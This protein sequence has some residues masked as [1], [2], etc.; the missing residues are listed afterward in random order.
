MP[1]IIFAIISVFVS[2]ITLLLPA[3]NLLRLAPAVYLFLFLP[4]YC[5][6]SLLIKG[7]DPNTKLWKI[8]LTLP[9]S[10]AVVS[11]IVLSMN[12]LNI[13]HF[14]GL[15][16][17][18]IITLDLIS[19]FFVA[20]RGG[21][22]IPELKKGF[23][24]IRHARPGFWQVMF[25][26]SGFILI[27]AIFYAAYVPKHIL[28]LTEFYI[29]TNDRE[30]PANVSRQDLTSAGLILGIGNHEGKDLNY[31]VKVVGRT[32]NAEV[33]I[34]TNSL[35]IRNDQTQELPILIN[36][37]PVEIKEVRIMLFVGNN[38]QSYRSLSLIIN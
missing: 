32:E 38:T 33:E 27:I 34:W 23:E 26:L 21:F 13:Y 35:R 2:G 3:P 29:L 30:L 15:T 5:V 1:N 17:L 31:R 22:Q 10:V 16:I 18:V 25:I 36:N 4:G 12:Y 11:L 8:A 14:N 20:R 7:D 6:C 37:L 24:K 9:L 19:S 28:P